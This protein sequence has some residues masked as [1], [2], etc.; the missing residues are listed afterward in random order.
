MRVLQWCVQ[1]KFLRNISSD[2]SFSHTCNANIESA[3]TTS[4]S[5]DYVF[6]RLDMC[7]GMRR[8]HILLVFLFAGE[9][10]SMVSV[11]VTA[12]SNSSHAATIPFCANSLSDKVN[13][14]R[15]I[16]VTKLRP[17]VTD[18]SDP[19]V[20]IGFVF[21]DIE[22]VY[23]L[24]TP[25]FIGE[26]HIS[27]MMDGILDK[28]TGIWGWDIIVDSSPD[29]SRDVVIDTIAKFASS[30]SGASNCKEWC[31]QDSAG[32]N[33]ESCRHYGFPTYIRVITADWPLWETKAD[34]TVFS[35]HLYAKAKYAVS[36]QADQLVLEKA[37]NIFL[38]LPIAIW[39]ADVISVSASCAENL[40]CTDDGR[41]PMYGQ[42]GSSCNPVGLSMLHVNSS[43]MGRVA[44]GGPGSEVFHIRDSSTRGPLLFHM[45][46]LR[47]LGF[48]D[49]QNYILGNDDHDLHLR[50]YEHNQYVTGF[51]PIY[52]RN[53]KRN[54]TVEFLL[55]KRY[56]S[57]NKRAR[58]RKETVM[59]H[60][61]DTRDGG[62]E[63]RP[64]LF[65]RSMSATDNCLLAPRMPNARG[66]TGG[67]NRDWS[68]SQAFA[69]RHRK[70]RA[71][72]MKSREAA[73]GH[74]S[75]RIASKQTLQT[76]FQTFNKNFNE[77]VG[78]SLC[79]CQ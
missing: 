45:G 23:V 42:I 76:V 38:S 77:V 58:Y 57:S 47:D 27:E 71:V 19:Y 25:V 2:L 75:K 65:N 70:V 56:L 78:Q 41:R 10:V 64:L 48:F 53:I 21:N 7:F 60:F 50:A 52:W 59:R 18:F 32:S 12:I 39:P 40:Q 3:P 17:R 20:D 55:K 63:G 68:V 34:N 51:Y 37:W 72:G 35:D 9:V 22:P 31:L 61:L 29:R 6:V 28:T 46:K 4:I 43:T 69:R 36:V 11:C 67:G 26:D 15:S 14:L 44:L 13:S 8:F 1:M 30:Y 62:K 54:R 24:S 33:D 49:E 79:S 66:I 16:G 5:N 74:N 73:G